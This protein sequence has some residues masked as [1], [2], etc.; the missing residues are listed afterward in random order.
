MQQR[1]S[2]YLAS[3]FGAPA[4]T[5]DQKLRVRQNDRVG[6]L[7][8]YDG[9]VGPDHGNKPLLVLVIMIVLAIGGWFLVDHIRSASSLQDCV[10]AGHR[11]CVPVD[12]SQSR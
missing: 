3:G 1:S 5:A 7:D 4:I 9:E 8:K 2:S 11:N 12:E 10:Q 6:R